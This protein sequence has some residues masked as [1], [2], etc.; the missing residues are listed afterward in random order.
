M[1]KITDFDY[2]LPSE[3]IAHAPATPRDSSKLL[4]IDRFTQEITNKHFYDLAD[5]LSD[6]YVIVRNNTKV[7]PARIYGEKQSGGKVE[8][9][10]LKRA[11]IGKY[12]EKWEVMTKPGLKL[13]QEVSFKNSPLRAT[14]IGVNGYTRVVEFNLQAE[15]LFNELDQIGH[16]P[17]PPYINWEEDDEK[18]LRE[19]YQT[20]YAKHQGSAAAP[21]AG[22]H[23]TPELDEKIKSKG[24]QIYEVTLHVGLGTFLPVKTDQIT[25][26][27]MH[28]EKYILNSE[29]AKR[30]NQAKKE[31][32][33][34]LSVGTTTT[35]LLEA[36]S[37]DRGELISGEAETKIFIYPQ[38]QY[39]FVDAIITNFHLPKSTLLMMISAFISKPNT[40]EDFKTFKQSLVGKAYLQ[41]I[42]DDYRFYSFG[43]GMIIL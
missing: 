41:A 13:G 11:G 37:N 18:K 32:K 3:N 40:G 10:L 20:I 9:L 17:I 35:R 16:T 39:K 22:L 6:E 1:F 15:D 34:I 33:K 36:C 7:I 8:L 14:T 38:Y 29:T 28:S 5:L 21:T 4:V 24:I 25:D 30:L 31:G 23:F 19:I 43:D 27:E 12:G 42:E 26:H 2:H